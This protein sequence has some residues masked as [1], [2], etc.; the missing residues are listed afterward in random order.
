MDALQH[1]KTLLKKNA[2]NGQGSTVKPSNDKY[3]FADKYVFARKAADQ[4][5]S[6]AAKIANAVTLDAIADAKAAKKAKRKE[7]KGSIGYSH[8]QLIHGGIHFKAGKECFVTVMGAPTIEQWVVGPKMDKR[9]L[10]FSAGHE[11]CAY[12]VFGYAQFLSSCFLT[13]YICRIVV[14]PKLTLSFPFLLHNSQAPSTILARS[15][16]YTVAWL[17]SGHPSAGE[18]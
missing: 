17:K 11:Q 3:N 4:I 15:A 2:R 5:S 8:I 13:H 18:P 10:M 14:V 7:P 6:K 16:L 12:G 1:I 9:T